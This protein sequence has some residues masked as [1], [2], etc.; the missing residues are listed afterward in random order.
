MCKKK[1][2][3]KKRIEKKKEITTQKCTMYVYP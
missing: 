3:E 2:K 1:R